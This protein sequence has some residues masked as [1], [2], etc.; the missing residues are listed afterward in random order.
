MIA[1]ALLPVRANRDGI[2]RERQIVVHVGV[3]PE[4]HVLQHE[5]RARAPGVE[6]KSPRLGNVR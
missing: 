1:I 3:D 4:Q 6:A 5:R 2:E